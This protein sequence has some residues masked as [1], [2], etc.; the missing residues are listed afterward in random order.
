MPP[1]NKIYTGPAKVLILYTNLFM[2][3]TA[4]VIGATGLIG[5]YVVQQ[6]LNDATYKTVRTISRRPTGLTHAKLDERIVNFED[7]AQ[8]TE[9]VGQ[10]DVLFSCMGTTN[11]NVKGNKA[12]YKFIDIDIP[13]MVAATAYANN[14]STC[15]LVSAIGANTKSGNFYIQLK[16]MAEEKIIESK[17]SSIH[18]FQPSQLLGNRKNEKRTLEKIAQVIISGIG[19]LFVGAL[20]KF[21]PIHYTEVGNAMLVA[22]KK[23]TPG[24]Y[25]YTYKE[26]KSLL[27]PGA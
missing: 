13:A 2:Q 11:A 14:Y 4:L 23:N 26:M 22:A 16:G 10:G 21:K 17:L 15:L 25:R 9:A 6:L 18:I 8:L 5:N 1:V 7:A 27:S 12:L 20:T 19:F 24:V 3:K